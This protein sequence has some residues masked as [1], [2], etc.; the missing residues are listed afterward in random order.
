VIARYKRP[1]PKRAKP[2]RT[3]DELFF[4]AP[5]PEAWP[6]ISLRVRTKWWED[7]GRHGRLLCGICHLLILNWYELVPDHIEP[8]KMGGCKDH[9]ESNL[10]PAHWWCN[11]E[12]GSVRKK[13]IA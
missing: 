1:N 11:N 2:R 7:K 12:K 3:R 6:K 5:K 13:D 10:Q 9:S 4:K 8:G